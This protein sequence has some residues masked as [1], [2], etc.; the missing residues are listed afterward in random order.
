MFEKD[1]IKAMD[2]FDTKNPM[3]KKLTTKFYGNFTPTLEKLRGCLELKPN[4]KEI[5][6]GI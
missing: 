5:L 6:G 4:E 2:W 1:T 3:K